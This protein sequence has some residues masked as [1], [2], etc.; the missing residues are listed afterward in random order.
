MVARVGEADSGTMARIAQLIGKTNQFNLTTRRHSAAE[1]AALAGDPS[2]VVAWL[3]LSDRFGDQ[4]LVAVGIL[5]RDGES[6][7]LDTFLMSCRV[8]NRGVERA[9]ASYLV[10]HARR[11]GC[12]QVVGE[13]LPTRKNSMVK[14]LYPTLGFARA[15]ETGNRFVLDLQTS[16]IEWPGAIRREDAASPQLTT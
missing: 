11:L 6:G 3:R 8:M 15:D 7:T 9:F 16:G 5:K 1:I 12:R 2:A 14:D 10:E 13:Y 4:G